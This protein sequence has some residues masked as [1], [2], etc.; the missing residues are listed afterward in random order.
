MKSIQTK[1]GNWPMDITVTRN[2]DLVYTDSIDRTVN[3]VNDKDDIEPVITLQGWKPHSVSGSFIGGLL[4]VMDSDDNN[5]AKVI[6]FCGSIE[7]Q[8]IQFDADGFPLYS[9]GSIK[10]ISENRNLDVCVSDCVAGQL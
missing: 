2:G 5:H 8:S 6:H 10:K 1:S 9:S 3:L 7:I 4:I